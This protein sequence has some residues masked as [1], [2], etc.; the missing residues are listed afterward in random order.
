MAT[1]WTARATSSGMNRI[2]DS[3]ADDVREEFDAFLDDAPE[4]G[5]GVCQHY[6]YRPQEDYTLPSPFPSIKQFLPR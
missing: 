5:L 3:K 4:I 6:F 1:Y 2:F